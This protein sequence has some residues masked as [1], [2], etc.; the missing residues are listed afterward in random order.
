VRASFFILS[1]D[2]APLLRHSLPA[3]AAEQP[4]ELVL[5][6][7]ASTDE[8]GDLGREHAT[9]VVRLPRR[10]SYCEAMNAGI[11]ACSGDAVALLQADTFVAA[12][13]REAA[14]AA[15]ADPT[16]GSVAPRL[17]RT[18]GPG[19]APTDEL[20]TAGMVVDR[21][22]KNGLVGHGT[23]AA[24]WSARCEVFGADGA[25]AVY[26]REALLDG[27]L[28]AEVFDP[29]LERWASDADV[30]WRAR[31]MGWRAVYEPSA[32]V[33]HMRTY[34]PSTRAVMS[35][36]SR[37]MQFRNRY[38][39]MVKNDSWR[40]LRRDLH[41]V[42]LYELLALGH[43]LLRERELLPAYAEARRRLPAARARRRHV[44][45]RRRVE[46]VPFGL[47]ARPVS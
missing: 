46:R 44:Q 5:V 13:Y 6:D 8:T 26:R 40:E 19:E 9:K 47:A 12:G 37:R 43:A 34:S 35:A 11:A 32:L 16:V 27:A 10:A 45:A 21:R 22:R 4:D 23:P 14:L 31:V 17:V 28:G 30:A 18:T 3:A 42:A 24:D 1:T 33:H 36:E 38:L 41:R 15:L 25:A 20:D 2:E 39:M 7:N 29:D